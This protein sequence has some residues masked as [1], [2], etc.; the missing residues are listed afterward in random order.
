[1]SFSGLADR[2]ALE[3]A[4]LIRSGG[5]S[6]EEVV[7]LFLDQIDRQ[8]GRVQ[9]FVSV[10]RRSIAVARRKD[11]LRRRRRVRHAPFD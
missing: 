11:A 6:S 4:A 10:F 8:N 9:A 1:M 2:S 7:R 3:L 5:V